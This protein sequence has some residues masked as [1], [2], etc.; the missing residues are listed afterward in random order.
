MFHKLALVI[1]ACLLLA[2]CDQQAVIEKFVPKDDDAFARRFLE[3]VRTGDYAAASQMLDLS[4]QGK[5]SEAGLRSL[6]TVLAHGGQLSVEVIG[7]NISSNLSGG[8]KLMD[9]SYQI[10]FADMYAAGDVVIQHTAAGGATILGAHF[11]LLPDSLKEI[12]RF[13]FSGK[14]IVHYLIFAICI[15]APVLIIFALIACIRTPIRKKWL[16]II[17]ILMGFGQ[18]QFAWTSGQLGVR[19][20]Y[21]TILGAGVMRSSSYASWIFSFSAPLGAILFLALRRKLRLPDKPKTP[22]PLP[23]PPPTTTGL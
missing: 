5:K 3:L 21:F 20:F 7:F 18:F 12:N 14:S 1:L 10:R 4:Q 23:P 8:N 9:L 16:W 11:Q 13:T 17:F 22:P 15:A 6:N 19:L 2:G